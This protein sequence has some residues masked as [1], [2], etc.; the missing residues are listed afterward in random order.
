VSSLYGNSTLSVSVDGAATTQIV[1][2]DGH[3]TASQLLTLLCSELNTLASGSHF[4]FA[5][6]DYKATITIGAGKTVRFF[7]SSTTYGN[8]VYDMIGLIS[9]NTVF[10]T[11]KGTSIV[12]D[13]YVNFSNTLML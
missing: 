1:F 2:P 9:T 6:T 7:R 8:N 4:T 13:Y 5:I 10:T 3:Y 12:G 11:N